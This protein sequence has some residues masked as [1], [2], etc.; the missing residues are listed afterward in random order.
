[1]TA[2]YS[3]DLLGASVETILEGERDRAFTRDRQEIGRSPKPG[4][5]LLAEPDST[6]IDIRES[7]SVGKAIDELAR[8]DMRA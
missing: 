8:L 6:F 4:D 7:I 3:N 1:M 5:G 2:S